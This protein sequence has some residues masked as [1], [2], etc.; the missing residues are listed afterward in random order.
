MT[1]DVVRTGTEAQL[2]VSLLEAAGIAA[3]H[4]PTNQA[5]GAFDGATFGAGARE[6]LVDAQDETAA[7]ELLAA[8]RSDD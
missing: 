4:R 1:I 7:R 3:V 2:V 8:Q 6:I 5:A